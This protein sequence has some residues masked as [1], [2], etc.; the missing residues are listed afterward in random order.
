MDE[1]RLRFILARGMLRTVLARYAETPPQ[2]LNFT[3]G[4]RGKPALLNHPLQFNLAHS[5]D[6]LLLALTSG[7]E[8]GVDVEQIRPL[9]HLATMA[10]DNFSP[11]EVKALYL[12]PEDQREIAFL[13]IWTRKEAFIK[14]TGDGFKRPLASFDVSIDEPAQLLRAEGEDI[15]QWTL[16]HLALETGYV[17]ALCINNGSLRIMSQQ[18]RKL[19]S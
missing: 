10:Q 17:G 7:H 11:V 5:G 4:T 13:K 15:Q 3:Y 8:L 12:L 16:Y 18:F 19:S 6:L 14:A 9:P 2:A 1:A